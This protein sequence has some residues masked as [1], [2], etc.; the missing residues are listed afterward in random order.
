MESKIKNRRDFLKEM[1]VYASSTAFLASIPWLDAF[2]QENGKN[3]AAS[4]RVRIAVI[5]VGSRGR[6]LLM[7]LQQVENVEIVAV[8][9]NYEPHYSRAIELTDGKAK[10]FYDHKKMIDAVKDIDAVVVA[11]PLHEHAHIVVDC[12]NADIHVFCEKAMART[13]VDTKLMADTAIAKGKIL[14]I[15]QQRLFNPVYLNALERVRAGEIGQ[16]TQVRAYWHRNADWRRP[17]PSPELERKINWRMYNE[18]SGG[19]MTELAAHQVQVANWYIDKVPTQVMGSGSIC[20]WKDGREVYDH[21]ALV[22]DYPDGSKCTYDSMIANKHH[23]LEEQIMGNLGTIEPEINR[24]YSEN[25]PQA[26]GIRQLV[27]DIE[28]SIFD[29]IPIGGATWIPETAVQYRG[30]VIAPY[31]NNDSFLQFVGFAK[32]VKNNK[33]YPNLL[34]EG[35]HAT[36]AVLLGLQAMDTNEIVAW[37]AEYVMEKDV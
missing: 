32:A 36:I 13:L 33:P 16:I 20:F 30:D 22:Y 27:H 7:N 37:P 1:G 21:V 19:L 3:V 29:V 25:P 9:D 12:L 10:A 14:Q 23:G 6:A 28:S 2:A 31:E 35:Y 17:V 11:T 15:G 34:R 5:G 8:C 24:I 26:P 18:Y 4:D